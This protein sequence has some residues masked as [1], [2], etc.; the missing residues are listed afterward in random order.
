VVCSTCPSSDWDSSPNNAPDRY[1]TALDTN[2]DQ[3]ILIKQNQCSF[4]EYALGWPNLLTLAFLLVA[5]GIFNMYLRAREVRFDEDKV[6]TSDY[7]VLVSN[8]PIDAK[9]PDEWRDFFQKFASDGD[10]VTTVTIALDNEDLV[11]SL[12]T[13][14]VSRNL[15]R[16][17][18]SDD[19]NEVDLDNDEAIMLA[20]D[21]YNQE[22]AEQPVGC[23]GCI[24][25]CIAPIFKLLGMMLSADE[26]YEKIRKLTEQI[27]ELQEKEYRAIRVFV[28]FETENGQRTALSA[29][30][31]GKAEL[32]ANRLGSRPP[33]CHFRGELLLDVEEPAE[34]SAIRYM[35]L[36]HTTVSR[37]IRRS[38]T[39][40]ITC[41]LIGFASWAVFRVRETSGPWLSGPLTTIFN[42]SMPMVLKLLLLLE[43]HGDEGSYQRSVYLKLTLF[44][45]TLS[46]VLTAVRPFVDFCN[47]IFMMI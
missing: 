35:E 33:D 42:S 41:G 10:Q 46:G 23:I 40:T 24:L 20:I 26:L 5:V 18:L 4:D 22:L 43:K 13:R 9:D 15:L 14:R 12:A 3:T 36:S 19:S 39:L 8:P 25:K 7:T 28:T 47:R 2:G 11:N 17:K 45:W 38:I 44:R 32:K 30:N 34:P 6:T 37:L 31:V 16:L 29:L 1:A 27:K 21:K